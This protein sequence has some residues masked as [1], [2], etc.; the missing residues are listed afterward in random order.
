MKHQPRTSLSTVAALAGAGFVLASCTST[1]D[2][3]ACPEVSAPR[4][5]TQAFMR[6]DDKR[7]VIDVRMNGVRG[8]CEAA[9]GGGTAMRVSVGLKLK[10]AGGENLAAG[11]A[12]V[13]LIGIV[14]DPDNN[15]VETKAIKY[16]TGF[17]KDQRLNYP[18]AEYEVTV[19]DG[20]RLV[21]SLLPA[22]Y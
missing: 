5:G 4:E 10:R 15:V 9:D 2:Y 12:Q 7:E 21:L 8:L 16:K 13:D 17:A 18:V 19:A 3:I 1:P 11:V 22:L 20:N 14:V 6:M